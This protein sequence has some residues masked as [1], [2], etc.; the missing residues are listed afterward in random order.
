MK[1]GIKGESQ[2]SDFWTNELN[3]SYAFQIT[4]GNNANSSEFVN[5]E[6][7]VAFHYWLLKLIGI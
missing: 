1:L 6:E 2:A 4:A 3:I 7:N 5:A